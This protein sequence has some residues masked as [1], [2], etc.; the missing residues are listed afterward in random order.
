MVALRCVYD[1]AGVT[2]NPCNHK[3]VKGTMSALKVQYSP[4][5][6]EVAT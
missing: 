1:E 2:D 5:R 3:D 4:P 6:T